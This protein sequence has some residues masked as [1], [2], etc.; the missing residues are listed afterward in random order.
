[1]LIIDLFYYIYLLLMIPDPLYFFVLEEIFHVCVSAHLCQ[2]ALGGEAE[3]V[4]GVRPAVG[5]LPKLLRRLSERH[6]GGD[7]AVD[8]GLLGKKRLHFK[9]RWLTR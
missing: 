3:A 4:D 1:M 5:P 9:K 7:G 6:V 8:N 2:L